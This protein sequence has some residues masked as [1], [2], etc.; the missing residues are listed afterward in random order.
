MFVKIHAQMD[1]MSLILACILLLCVVHN[2][3]AVMSC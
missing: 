1:Q 2:I 3:I